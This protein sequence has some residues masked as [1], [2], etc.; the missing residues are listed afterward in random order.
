MGHKGSG[1]LSLVRSLLAS[2]SPGDIVL[3]DALYCNYFLIAALMAA[4]VD[5]LMAQNGSRITDFECDQSL[6]AHDHVV[7]WREG[8]GVKG[9]L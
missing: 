1:E 3:A 9:L 4:G 7:H 6:G 5:V 2:F 8:A